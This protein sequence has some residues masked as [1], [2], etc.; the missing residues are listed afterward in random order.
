MTF[1]V[2][3]L[4]RFADAGVMAMRATGGKTTIEALA[5]TPS[6][7]VAVMV[8]VPAPAAVAVTEA[9]ANAASASAGVGA[10]DSDATPALPV[11]QVSGADKRLLAESY[12]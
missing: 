8:V 4:V 5:E 3:P 12:A 9:P 7:A 1:T 10:E 11:L 6:A 2:W